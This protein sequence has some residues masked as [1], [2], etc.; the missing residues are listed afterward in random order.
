VVGDFAAAG[1]LF[2]ASPADEG[3]WETDI[4]RAV[5]ATVF[6]KYGR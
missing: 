3:L 6:S 5:D 2:I 4:L 1:R